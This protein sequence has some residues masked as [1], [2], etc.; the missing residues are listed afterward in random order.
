MEYINRYKDKYLFTIDTDG[1]VL[2]TGP[3]KYI[4]VGFLN[5]LTAC[6]EAYLKD[7]PNTSF[8]EFEK[9]IY[10]YVEPND[11]NKHGYYRHEKYFEL[12]KTTD[13]LEMVD[14]SGGPYIEVGQNLKFIDNSLDGKIIKEI[15]NIKSGYKLIVE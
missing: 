5:D 9:S 1:N 8:E 2:W 10:D 13:K 11:E 3:F 12:I 14:P 7:Y 6:Y 15:I 4:R